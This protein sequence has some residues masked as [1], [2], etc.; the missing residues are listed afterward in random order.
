VSWVDEDQ[1]WLPWNFLV[2]RDTLM[3]GGQSRFMSGVAVWQNPVLNRDCL[4]A[5]IQ[6]AWT[7]L[8]GGWKRSESR[9]NKM[10]E[11]SST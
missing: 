9:A 11:V 1:A 6:V 4:V 7:Y 10:E 5:V 8:V 2:G 3:T